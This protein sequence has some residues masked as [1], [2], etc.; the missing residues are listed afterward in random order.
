M[1]NVKTVTIRLMKGNKRGKKMTE[2]AT[3]TNNSYSVELI[4]RNN[5]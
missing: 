2:E 4:W 5:R 3:S 1:K